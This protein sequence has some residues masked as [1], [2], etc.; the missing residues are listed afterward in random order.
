M[1]E[2]KHEFIEF[3]PAEAWEKEAGFLYPDRDDEGNDI[4]II[5]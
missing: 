2:N 1:T 4:H 3:D 5:N